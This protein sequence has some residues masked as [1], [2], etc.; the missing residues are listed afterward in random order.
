MVD[1]ADESTSFVSVELDAT[2]AA[3]SAAVFARHHHVE[4]LQGDWRLLQWH[5]PFD[6]L[7]LDGG[8]K[9]KEPG[10]DPLDPAEWLSPGGTIVLDDFTPS[11]SPNASAHDD[12]RRHWLDNPVLRAV[13]LRLSRTLSTIVG[14]RL[15]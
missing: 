14:T 11:G 4:V 5:G 10:D 1:A 13:E 2:R 7:V 3:A 15:L 8:G 9:G 12:V 6:L